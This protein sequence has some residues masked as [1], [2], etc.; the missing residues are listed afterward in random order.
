MVTSLV[1]LVVITT[2]VVLKG[3]GR[4]AAVVAR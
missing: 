3:R 2:L 4:Y 1:L